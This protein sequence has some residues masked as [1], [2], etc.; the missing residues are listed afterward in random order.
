MG[1]TGEV[2]YYIRVIISVISVCVHTSCRDSAHYDQCIK[3]GLFR[4]I[5]SS[6]KGDNSPPVKTRHIG[7]FSRILQRDSYLSLTRMA[8]K[9]NNRYSVASLLTRPSASAISAYKHTT[10]AR[11]PH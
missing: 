3:S 5:Q 7:G 8:H 11:V 6:Y 4:E 2:E 1:G 9:R 10:P